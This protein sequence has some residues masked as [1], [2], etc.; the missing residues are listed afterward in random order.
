MRCASAEDSHGASCRLDTTLIPFSNA[1]QSCFKSS[2]S[3]GRIR[4]SI[5]WL[6]GLVYVGA[7]PTSFGRSAPNHAMPSNINTTSRKHR[8]PPLACPDHLP[9]LVDTRTLLLCCKARESRS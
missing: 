1:F 6:R 4:P 9:I 7:I 2:P 8:T 3:R 5:R